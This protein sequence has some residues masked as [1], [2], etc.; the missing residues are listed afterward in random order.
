MYVKYCFQSFL[1]CFACIPPSLS[2]LSPSPPLH[3]HT[4]THTHPHRYKPLIPDPEGDNI[5]CSENTVVFTV[6]VFQYVGLVVALSTAAPYRRP[7]FTNCESGGAGRVGICCRKVGKLFGGGSG[8]V[9]LGKLLLY[10]H[11]HFSPSRTFFP[12]PPSLPPSL[13]SPP[14]FLPSSFPPLPSLLTSP[15]L[16]PYLPPSLLPDW[17]MLCLMILLPLNL[18]IALAPASWWS[19]FWWVMQL[20]PPASLS[21][22][23]TIVEIALIYC[24]IAYLLEVCVC[25]G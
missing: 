20:E 19:W 18:Y 8:E 16:S 7:L 9:T 21:F 4:H 2:L 1:A 15:S 11:T 10:I 17:F 5:V 24:T 6:S 23:I 14:P 12:L 22:R 13:S 25:K 3:T